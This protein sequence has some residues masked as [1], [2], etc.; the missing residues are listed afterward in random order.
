MKELSNWDRWGPDDE[1][2]ASNLITPAKR[3]QAAALVKEGLTISLAHDVIQ[4]DAADAGSRLDRVVLNASATG[5]ADRYQ[6]TGT[7]HGA[8]RSHLDAVDCHVMFEGKGYSGR[9]M[10]GLLTPRSDLIRSYFI[11]SAGS[12]FRFPRKRTRSIRRS[13]AGAGVSSSQSTLSCTL[14][15][16]RP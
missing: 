9:S 2:G 16:R 15:D 4:E 13:A 12:T 14:S 6:D 5:A 10:E 3:K 8:I 11:C 1:L 7:Y